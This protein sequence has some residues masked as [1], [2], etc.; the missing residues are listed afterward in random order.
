M[1]IVDLIWT[2]DNNQP[3]VL[4]HISTMDAISY[5]SKGKQHKKYLS[6]SSDNL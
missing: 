6:F 1:L 5:V 3:I 2:G 4:N